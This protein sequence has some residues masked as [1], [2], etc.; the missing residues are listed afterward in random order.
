MAARGLRGPSRRSGASAAQERARQP[1]GRA[2]QDVF[3]AGTRRKG[4]AG[5][6]GT[7]NGP[8]LGEKICAP[9]VA[10]AARGRLREPTQRRKLTS[11]ERDKPQSRRHHSADPGPVAQTGKPRTQPETRVKPG[12]PP[13]AD[14][15]ASGRRRQAPLAR[16]RPRSRASMRARSGPAV[17]VADITPWG[18]THHR[19]KRLSATLAVIRQ[20]DAHAQKRH[21]HR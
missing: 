1:A 5:V 20:I 3:P 4:C 17:L 16:P 6:A 7:R 9:P 15:P 12:C 8:R 11:R 2:G 10:S 19:R 21:R 13:L 18:A 14:Q